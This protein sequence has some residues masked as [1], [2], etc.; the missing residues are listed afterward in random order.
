MKKCRYALLKKISLRSKHL[1]MLFLMASILCGNIYYRPVEVK[2]VTDPTLGE[3][4]LSLFASQ[5]IGLCD[6]NILSAVQSTMGNAIAVGAEGIQNAITAFETATGGCDVITKTFTT[7]AG[8]AVTYV[9]QVGAENIIYV[10]EFGASAAENISAAIEN[11]QNFGFVA[12]AVGG[13]SLIP[14]AGAAVLAVGAGVALGFGINAFREYITPYV[15]SGIGIGKKIAPDVSG[16]CVYGN[17]FI[18][19]QNLKYNPCV[20]SNNNK[21]GILVGHST[22]DRQKFWCVNNSD[23]AY[24]FTALDSTKHEFWSANTVQPG[25]YLELWCQGGNMYGGITGDPIDYLGVT[26]P[27]MTSPDVIDYSGNLNS[28]SG[29][30]DNLDVGYIEPIPMDDYANWANQAQQNTEGGITSD[31]QGDAFK[32]LVDRYVLPNGPN[33]QPTPDPEPSTAPQ[34]TTDPAAPVWPQT[35]PN[36]VNPIQPTYLP[37]PTADPDAQPTAVPVVPPDGDLTPDQTGDLLKKGRIPG[38]ENIFPFCIPF[39]IASLVKKLNV[40]R[41]APV[42]EWES[43]FGRWGSFGDVTIDLSSFDSVASMA[44]TFELIL[45]I[46]GLMIITKNLIGW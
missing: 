32:D 26:D 38:L 1:V 45:F 42:I 15:T 40:T 20:I 36:P 21:D 4:V 11:Y 22:G 7:T 44:R 43:D 24:K 3:F 17:Y 41:R 6:P 10:K 16:V 46:L 19:S 39:D 30:E 14:T 31:P 12:P 35:N 33:V 5:G 18:S 37:L 2:A 34:P 28:G 27:V 9:Q 13:M 23:E 25:S 8:Q 29:L